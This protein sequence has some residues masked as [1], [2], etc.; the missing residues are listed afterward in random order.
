MPISQALSVVPAGQVATMGHMDE[1][2]FAALVAAV[3]RC[4]MDFNSQ[5]LANTAWAIATVGH[6]D[7]QLFP[8]TLLAAAA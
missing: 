6:K 7:E 3:E 4:M 5:E 1:Q 8:V 2:L